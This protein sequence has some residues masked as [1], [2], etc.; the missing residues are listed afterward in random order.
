MIQLGGKC[1]FPGDLPPLPYLQQRPE[2][3][4]PTPLRETQHP[5]R[6]TQL[7]P[8]LGNH[9]SAHIAYLQHGI[10]SPTAATITSSKRNADE[11]YNDYYEN[12]SPT[13]LS[14]PTSLSQ[15]PSI[16]PDLRAH[17]QILA[18]QSSVIH[19]HSYPRLPPKPM[20]L[21]VLQYAMPSNLQT[22][23]EGAHQVYTQFQGPYLSA[24]MDRAYRGGDKGGPTPIVNN[25][26][27]D[28]LYLDT[29]NMNVGIPNLAKLTPQQLRDER[30][31]QKRLRES[32]DTLE[33][34]NN[35]TVLRDLSSSTRLRT[36]GNYS[37]DTDLDDIQKA[38][39]V[40]ERIDRR[41]TE[42]MPPEFRERFAAIESGTFSTWWKNRTSIP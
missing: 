25:P 29:Q 35:N 36:Y 7:L 1:L 41:L 6:E 3:T 26:Y 10:Y 14:P 8:G 2:I 33:P 13:R 42:A 31:R 19:A 40:D 34:R 38:T 30:Q 21:P 24:N 37:E 18:S 27:L 28:T 22:L 39:K 32:P 20:D 15:P 16:V 9:L 11:I 12:S 17:E 23:N 4:H 5:L